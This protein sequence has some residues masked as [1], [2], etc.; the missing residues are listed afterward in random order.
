MTEETQ[1][2]RA[3]L[4]NAIEVFRP[5][6]ANVVAEFVASI[7][8]SIGGAASIRHGLHSLWVEGLSIPF[9]QSGETCWASV[10]AFVL[11]GIGAAI[12][13]IAFARRFVVL[14]FRRVEVCSN[15]F[16]YGSRI[17]TEDV[18][19]T[20]VSRI[21]ETILYHNAPVFLGQGLKLPVPEVFR[22]SYKVVTKSRK[23]YYFDNDSIKSIKRFGLHLQEQAVLRSLPWE[24]TKN[25]L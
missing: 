19:W 3:A 1:S 25:Y 12:G 24:T 21:D 13:G 5:M 6:I 11:I 14:A 23:W 15:G 2:E 7:S 8:L 4:S 20:F 16:R 17:S 10:G 22:V 18:P 9:Y